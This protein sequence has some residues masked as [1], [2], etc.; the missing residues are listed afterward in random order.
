MEIKTPTVTNP[1][2]PICIIVMITICPNKD[3]WV[4]VS[5]TISPVTQDALVAVNRQLKKS[6]D[7]P[8]L[9][10]I[11]SIKSKAPV[12]IRQKNP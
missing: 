2:P 8:S 4:Q 7:C 10:E 5:L 6:S 9:L 3:H 12:K 11:G 1:R